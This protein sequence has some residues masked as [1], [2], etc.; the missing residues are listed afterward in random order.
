MNSLMSSQP[1]PE[2]QPA[3]IELHFNPRATVPDSERYGDRRAAHNKAALALPGRIAGLPY[4]DGPLMDLDIYLPEDAAGAPPVHVF[5]HGG[6]WRSR[7]KED[8][9]YLGAA[10]AGQGIMTVVINYPLCP[11]V[12]LDAV[13]AGARAA[14]EWVCRNIA[15]HGG[16]PDRITLSGHSAGAHLGAAIIA[17]D[18]P[19]HGLTQ[20][21]LAG[22][23]L[24]SGIYD[25]APARLTTV[26]AE[27]G[28]TDDLVRRHNYLAH[29][30][31][32]DC[33]VTV[34]AGGGEPKG[35]IAQSEAY[36]AHLRGSGRNVHYLVS[37]TDNHFELQDQYLDSRSDVMQAV[38]GLARVGPGQ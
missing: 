6:Y 35:W 3:E 14:I 23:V 32:L 8:F 10:L 31:R 37:G 9:A 7:T 21:P 11:A 20:E 19:T 5:V 22:A 17:E 16:D 33:P 24:I 29:P 34:I 2:M 1:W 38:L 28:L 13:V 36:A 27:I 4:G 25:P 30:P 18:W 12:D 15:A 26:N